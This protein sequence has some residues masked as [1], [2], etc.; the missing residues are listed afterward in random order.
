MVWCARHL[1]K[2]HEDPNSDPRYPQR[3][4]SLTVHICTQNITN[5]HTHTHPTE[6]ISVWEASNL[7]LPLYF[8]DKK[9][10]VYFLYHVNDICCLP[11]PFWNEIYK[12][13]IKVGGSVL[14][15]FPSRC[16]SMFLL[17]ISLVSLFFLLNNSKPHAPTLEHA[18]SIEA[19]PRQRRRREAVSLFSETSILE[20]KISKLIQFGRWQGSDKLQ[21]IH[22]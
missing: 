14:T 3:K 9:S 20:L 12:W 18:S 13:K 21:Q 15:E 10:S 11:L 2:K 7:N 19:G 22:S 6:R 17:F 8:P 16:C 5:E 1:S 4:Q